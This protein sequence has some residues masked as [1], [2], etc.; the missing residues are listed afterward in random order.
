MFDLFKELSEDIQTGVLMVFA[1]FLVGV[2]LITAA[3]IGTD[4][5]ERV[6]NLIRD[7]FSPVE[8]RCAIIGNAGEYRNDEGNWRTVPCAPVLEDNQ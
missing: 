1:I 8:A 5:S 7:G 2:L 3:H 6:E 4:D